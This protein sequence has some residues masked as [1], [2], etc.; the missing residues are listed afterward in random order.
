I[1]PNQHNLAQQFVTLDN[2][3]ATAEV[4]NDGWP[5]STSARA[6]DVVEHQYP[7][8]YAQRGL[9]LDTEGMN[10]NV[11]VAIPTLAQRQASDPLM[12][13]GAL[14]PTVTGG[15]D[16]LP[17]Q[18]D[19]DAPDGPDD[20]VNT[21][22][23]WNDAL[24]AG[25]TVRDYGFFVDTN[26][27]NEPRCQ[28]P[29]AHDPY[30]TGTIVAPPTNVAL[31][32]FTDQYFRGFDPA[33]PD[34]YRFREWERDFDANYT[35]GGLPNLTLIRF[36][37]D[38]TGSFGTAID[39]VNTPERDVADNDYAVGLVVQKI[40]NNPLYKNNTLIFVVEDDAQDGGDHMDSHRTTAYVAGAYVRN[41]TVSTAY[42]TLNFM[43][44]MEEVLGLPPMN[45][46]DA[47]AA[48]MCDIFNTS[49]TPWTFSATPAAILYCTQLPL[50]A[51]NTPCNDPTPNAAYWARVTRGMDFTDADLVDGQTFNRV[52]WKGMM[53]S[54]PYPSKPSGKD[55]RQNR[56]EL[57]AHYRRSVRTIG[58]PI[59]RPA[60]E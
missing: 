26:C 1:T 15:E 60:G 46:N 36:M 49:P 4:S 44:T 48:P 29:L 7:I 43:R 57:L 30:S 38:H 3:L 13:G 34:Y 16:L 24:R 41:A 28:T 39:K 5:W 10:R 31:A 27:Y 14:S 45:L 6:P 47:L 33:F 52:L 23:L 22:Y 2:F 50:P 56:E 20:E 21:G 58:L 12:P 42:T 54:K 8:N 53:G 17:G 37:H 55:L 40:A 11:N 59:S 9:S 18:A 35:N 51:S 19:V 32:P 25:L